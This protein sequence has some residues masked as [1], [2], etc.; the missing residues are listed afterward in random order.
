MSPMRSRRTLPLAALALL[1]V[2]AAVY[3]ASLRNGFVFDDTDY[4]ALNPAVATMADPARFFLDPSTL[5]GDPDLA[6]VNYR[7]LAALGFALSRAV[8]GLD[9]AKHHFLNAL[10]HALNSVLLLLLFWRLLP[11]LS[12]SLPEERRLFT[13]GL[14]AG[15]FLLHPVQTESVLWI[16]QRS[17]LQSMALML[18]AWHA[19]L[20]GRERA[21]RAWRGTGWAAFAA[22]LLTK[23]GAAVLPLFLL[24]QAWAAPAAQDR[25]GSRWSG[26]LLAVLPHGLILALFAAVKVA[27]LG[28]WGQQPDYWAGTLP[29]TVLT[30]LKAFTVY[31]RLLVRPWPLS[32]EHLVRPALTALDP[33]L[34]GSLVLHANL[35]VVAWLWRERDRVLSFG[36]LV[37]LTALLPFCN[38]IPI[39]A[40]VQERFL[41]VP[42]AGFSLAAAGLAAALACARTPAPPLWRWKAASAAAGVLLLACAM[43]VLRRT[44]DWSG[45]LPLFQSAARLDPLSARIQFGLGKEY[46]RTGRWQEGIRALRFSLAVNPTREGLL[47]GALL[48]DGDDREFW[49][50]VGRARVYMQADAPW[51]EGLMTLGT[52][53]LADGDYPAAVRALGLG[54]RAAP[55]RADIQ[56]NLAAALALSGDLPAA[57]RLSED[58]LRRHP[59]L[60]ALRE[61]LELMRRRRR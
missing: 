1:A 18:L 49:D 10:L 38:L 50:Q 48:V 7:P 54:A 3:S 53:L 59:E 43:L 47:R 42:M 22:A 37:Y 11:L 32:I 6:R 12:P 56:A 41:Y 52:E 25:P 24:A 13:A 44:A 20:T 15:I 8:L 17:G 36:I 19:E 30:T 45:N 16:A 34:L 57:I 9:P 4:L 55:D 2:G 58:L 5:A 35:L 27:A 61:N 46:P 40:I 14:G 26:R 33:V 21:S 23:E 60:T 39:G 31:L 29:A 28:R 51:P